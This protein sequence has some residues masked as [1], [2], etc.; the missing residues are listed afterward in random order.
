M[1]ND[2]P[3]LR[4]HEYAALERLY[5]MYLMVK[6]DDIASAR[7]MYEIALNEYLQTVKARHEHNRARRAMDTTKPTP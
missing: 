5:R 2:A 7:M 6:E 4:S 3:Y 1:E